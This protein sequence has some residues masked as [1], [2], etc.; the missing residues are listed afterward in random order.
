MEAENLNPVYDLALSFI[1]YTNKDVFLTGKAGT[2]KTTFLKQIR[3][4][5]YKKSIIVAPTGVSAINANGITIHALFNLPLRPLDP[6]DAS[7]TNAINFNAAKRKL[8]S[9]VELMIIDEVS[10]LR[11]DVLDAIDS[12]LRRIRRQPDV[13]FGG[14]QMF[15]IG[16]LFQL[17]PI[18]KA[19]DWSLLE[20]RYRSPFFID[21]RVF[22]LTAPVCLNLEKIYRQ[23]DVEFIQLLNSIRVGQTDETTMNILN[24]FYNAEKENEN[25]TIVLTTHNN[26]ADEINAA[27]LAALPGSLHSLT[28]EI[29]GDFSEYNYP[30]D[31]VLSLKIGAQVMLIRNDAGELKKYFNGKIGTVEDI[32]VDELVI[33]FTDGGVL[34]IKREIW[35]QI[36]YQYQ[37]EQ[38]DIIENEIGSF[39][40]FPVRLAWA[41]TIHKS[42]GLTFEK[43]FV[44]AESSFHPG[45]VY[46]ALSRLTS[47]AGLKLHS[48]IPRTAIHAHQRVVD[49]YKDGLSLELAKKQLDKERAKF[50]LQWVK[51]CLD[52]GKITVALNTMQKQFSDQELIT[53]VLEKMMIISRHGQIFAT[54]ISSKGDQVNESAE[55]FSTERLIKGLTYFNNA[56]SNEVTIPLRIKL[57]EIKH[58]LLQRKF[59]Q[60]LQQIIS[61]IEQRIK[62][63]TTAQR[64]V[65]PL[66][67]DLEKNQLMFG[68]RKKSDNRF[69]NLGKHKDYDKK[70]ELD[71]EY[72]FE[73]LVFFREGKSVAEIAEIRNLSSNTIEY[74][75]ASFLQTGEVCI[76]H[77]MDS[78]TYMAIHSLLVENPASTLSQIHENLPT[79]SYGQIF[80]A[81]LY[82]KL[83]N[84]GA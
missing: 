22:N 29:C 65:D 58:L 34:K 13:P 33:R 5:T 47:P 48:L 78:N 9:E 79:V 1:N 69:Q 11:A 25:N 53:Y 63:L 18:A 30:T 51:R 72:I 57:D 75:L 31:K 32:L 2:G 17:S 40:Q 45:Q 26:K 81:R 49:F 68:N 77:L 61:T 64:L 80:A 54:E 35:T 19:K 43:A 84:R 21:S 42:Q 10:M 3:S 66:C 41:I 59:Y 14:V 83:K 62:D 15:Y 28:A 39:R 23:S 44:D 24:S 76:E 70:G 27:R 12:I 55:S 82:E 46:V 73:S 67:T 7:G 16:D 37:P 36:D 8:L 52:F 4:K 74:H 6:E 20:K 50:N 56:L 60:S 71:R 38:D